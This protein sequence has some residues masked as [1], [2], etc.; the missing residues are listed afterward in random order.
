MTVTLAPPEIELAH[1]ENDRLHAQVRRLQTLAFRDLLDATSEELTS[2][3][4]NL[5]P[6]ERAAL[7]RYLNPL[8]EVFSVEERVPCDEGS[9]SPEWRIQASLIEQPASQR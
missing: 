1:H 5:I 7:H 9:R 8:V 3:I 2:A 4:D 6:A